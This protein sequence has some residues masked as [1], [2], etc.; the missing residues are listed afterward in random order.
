MDSRVKYLLFTSLLLL[1]G[2]AGFFTGK[3]TGSNGL[4]IKTGESKVTDGATEQRL[5]GY[6]Y[7][8]PL[9]ECD[10][11]EPLH[12]NSATR[13][14]QKVTDYIAGVKQAGKAVFV[15]VYFRDLNFGPWMGI[16]ELEKFS[17]ASLLKVPV[18]IATFKK[19]DE[20]QGFLNK[21][22]TYS[23]PHE[24]NKQTGSTLKPGSSYKI[25]NLVQLMI[26]QSDNEARIL[27]QQTLGD[28]FV[29]KVMTDIGVNTS[30]NMDSIFVSVKD[31]SGFF[32]LLYNATY[33]SRSMSEKAL[34][35]L[36][37]SNND[38]GMVAALPAGTLVANKFGISTG[39]GQGQTQ[40]HE[41]GIV[42]VAG[43]PY[44]LCIMTRGNNLQQLST[45]ISDLSFLVYNEVTGKQP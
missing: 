18:M 38:K 35:I 8:N 28:E 3:Y 39:G 45:V 1:A 44:L 34:Q 36:S 40:L 24:K 25:G 17:P 11:F 15:S 41:C 14:Q 4:V 43:S 10:N 2:C 29:N 12:L 19:E 7:I 6:K 31:Y 27:L 16:N 22:V 32:R 5:G 33:L 30:G 23:Q 21:T 26:T 37:N 20:E 13:M 42:Y 9:L